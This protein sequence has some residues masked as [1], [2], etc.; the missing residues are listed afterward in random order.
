M[1]SP[2]TCSSQGLRLSL[3][4]VERI[5]SGP[6]RE[7][8]LRRIG[9]FDPDLTLRGNRICTSKYTWYTLL[10]RNLHEQLP[11][12][13]DAH[14]L[15]T[16]FL[17]CI[18]SISNSFWKALDAGPAFH[19]AVLRGCRGSLRGSKLLYNSSLIRPLEELLH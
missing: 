4:A 16:S 18:P 13:G 1:P 15:V 17:Q 19:C 9:L 8:E 2:S 12:L 7:P 10:P 3:M 6:N 11:L 5:K 14:F